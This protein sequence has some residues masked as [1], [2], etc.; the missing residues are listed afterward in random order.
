M[1]QQQ[2]KGDEREPY[3]DVQE[4]LKDL[5]GLKEQFNGT[6]K[7]RKQQSAGHA[8]YENEEPQVALTRV[9]TEL[10]DDFTHY[11]GYVSLARCK[12]SSSSVSF[13]FL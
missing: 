6:M 13:R 9:I 5:E 11:K 12:C 7:G 8:P 10:E 1:R 2:N 4:R 3:R